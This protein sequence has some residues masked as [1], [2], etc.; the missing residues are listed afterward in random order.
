MEEVCSQP[1][2]LGDADLEL[3]SRHLMKMRDAM[4]GGNKEN[5]FERA[6]AS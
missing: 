2:I 3:R 6:A 5:S 4:A 1:Q